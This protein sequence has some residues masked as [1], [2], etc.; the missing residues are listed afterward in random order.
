MYLIYWSPFI[1][2]HLGFKHFNTFKILWEDRNLSS[3]GLNKMIKNY[4][5][6]K[7]SVLYKNISRDFLEVVK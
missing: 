7:T 4:V 1:D 2:H 6:V 3:K 5:T